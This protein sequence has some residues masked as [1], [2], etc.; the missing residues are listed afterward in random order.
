MVT[1]TSER[2]GRSRGRG[3][4][5]WVRWEFGRELQVTPV[6]RLITVERFLKATILVGGG[7]ALLVLNEREGLHQAIL[8]VEAQYNLESGRGLW[9]QLVDLV[10][11][12]VAGFPDSRIVALAVA[13]FL[14]AALEAFEGVGLLLRRRWAEYLVLV[15]TAVFLPVEIRELALKPSVFKGLALLVN[16]LIVAYLIWRK[17]LFLERP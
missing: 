17:R 10:L 14:Y 4:G 7:I 13:G 15:A 9:R 2:A 1:E 8:N 5:A 6:I 16:V 12:H 11:Q 3:L